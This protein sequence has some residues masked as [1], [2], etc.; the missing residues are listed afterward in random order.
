MIIELSQICSST[1]IPYGKEFSAMKI[2]EHMRVHIAQIQ[3][4]ISVKVAVKQND[5]AQSLE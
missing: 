2:K 3:F 4:F 5:N 1:D